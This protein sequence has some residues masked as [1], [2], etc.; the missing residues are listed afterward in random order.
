[1]PS[2]LTKFFSHIRASSPRPHSAIPS[3][4]LGH[5]S[6]R[7][8]SSSS[9][10]YIACQPKWVGGLMRDGTER[11][12]PLGVVKKYSESVDRVSI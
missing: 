11:W 7:R 1:M 4:Q 12:Y 3:A 8:M 10:E 6:V 9:A 2:L 5:E